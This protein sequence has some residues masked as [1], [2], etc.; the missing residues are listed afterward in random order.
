MY[1]LLGW[2]A[3]VMNKLFSRWPTSSSRAVGVKSDIKG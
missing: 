2:T 1:K 3:K